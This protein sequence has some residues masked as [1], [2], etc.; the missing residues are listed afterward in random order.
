MLYLVMIVFP[1]HTCTHLDS[2]L[3]P[4]PGIHLVQMDPEQGCLSLQGQLLGTASSHSSGTTSPALLG[5]FHGW[6]FGSHDL[7]GA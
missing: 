5:L 4:G 6:L 1:A 3:L 2:L 7:P